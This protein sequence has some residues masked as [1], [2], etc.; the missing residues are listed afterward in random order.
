MKP[1]LTRRACLQTALVAGLLPGSVLASPASP[2]RLAFRL[3]WP[4]ARVD[5]HRL[6]DALAAIVGGALFEPLFG[7][8]EDDTRVLLAE[9]FPAVE[10]A[11]LRVRVRKGMT[12][13]S[14][15]SVD[16]RDVQFSIARAR[17]FG[18]AAWLQ[19]VPVP[20]VDGDDLVFAMNDRNAL[21][22]ALSSP[23][24]SIVPRTF[25]PENPDGTGPF[26]WTKKGAA[27]VLVRNPSAPYGPPILDEV[28]IAF[29]PDL[30]SSLRAFE[31][32]S[33]DI[34]WLGA[35]LHEARAKS[36][37]FDRG[38]VGFAVLFTGA[39]AGSWDAPGIA[40]RLCDAIDPNRVAYLGLGGWKKDESVSWGGPR[41]EILVRDDSPW[42]IETA[43]AIAGALSRPSH[44]LTVK[45]VSPN[46]WTS[47]KG[48]HSFSLAVDFV[49]PL[50][51]T[52]FGTLLA[53]ASSFDPKRG[54]EIARRPPKFTESNARV[55]SRTL[56]VGIVGETR[57]R[58]A[59]AADVTLAPS[60]TTGIDWAA[61]FRS[62][63]AEP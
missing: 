1:R 32:A 28:E 56:R 36:V 4:T 50:D 21:I 13:A 62:Q 49:R 6:D 41:S 35:G 17:R 42:L 19:S 7:R 46:E 20:K 30:S 29:A 3:P 54:E 38:A 23:L 60:A 55:L 47:R 18:A 2:Q 8:N 34:G 51:H 15:K 22:Q 14:G 57:V 44:E 27:V 40:Q 24:V 48:S 52:S 31:G 59:H 39:M 43:K 61:S 5:P 33:D 12:F 16:A 11:T 58:G 25:V 9:S 63:K 10:A 45:P 37:S 53:L 26:R